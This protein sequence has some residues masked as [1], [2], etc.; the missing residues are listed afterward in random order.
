MNEEVKELILMIATGFFMLG[1]GVLISMFG[2][3]WIM[4]GCG[5]VLGIL[6]VTLS[7]AG[8]LSLTVRGVVEFEK[9]KKRGDENE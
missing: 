4:L 3:N 9:R 7:F 6:G 5:V 2:D 8:L 1:F